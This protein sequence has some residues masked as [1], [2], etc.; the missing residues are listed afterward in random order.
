[1]RGYPLLHR[2]SD[3]GSK[4]SPSSPGVPLFP[5]LA[6]NSP[7]FKKERLPFG[8]SF[9]SALFLSFSSLIVGIFLDRALRH[10]VRSCLPFILSFPL[11]PPPE[12]DCLNPQLFPTFIIPP[13]LFFLSSQCWRDS[14]APFPFSPPWS[15]MVWF[16]QLLAIVFRIG[17]P[18]FTRTPPV[19]WPLTCHCFLL[20]LL[21]HPSYFSCL[22]P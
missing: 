5:R 17:T 16:A 3:G 10:V 12:S 15:R 8:F 14:L 19:L 22:S 6:V 13:P 20:L 2:I 21:F 18:L 1:L 7:L 9:L 4:W 11:S